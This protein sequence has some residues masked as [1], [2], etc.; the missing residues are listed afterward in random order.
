MRKFIRACEIL[1]QHCEKGMD[2]SHPFTA[3]HDIIHSCVTAENLAEDSLDGKEL[4][5]LGWFIDG[6]VDVWAKY[7]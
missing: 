7:V 4:N 2:E 1:A 3:E 6:D 5:A